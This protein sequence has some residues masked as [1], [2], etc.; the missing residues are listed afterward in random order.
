[1]AIQH[2]LSAKEQE[3]LHQFLIEL[4]G[5]RT[6]VLL[7]SRANEAWLARETFAENMYELAGLDP[8]ATSLLANLILARHK[9]S[10]YGKDP[11]LLKLLKLL[12][13]FP[14]ALEVILANLARQT[15]TEVLTALQSGDTTLQA[16]KGQ[17]R[18][19]NILRCVDYSYSNLAPDIQSLLLCL[20]PF[21]SVIFQPTL[22]WYITALKQQPALSSL[23]FER[24]Q[25]VIQGATD[26]GLLMEDTD[27][28][29]FLRLQPV[30][31][32]FLRTRLSPPEYEKMRN[33]I[34]KAFREL[35]DQLGP[36]MRSL[37]NSKDPQERQIGQ[38]LVRMEYENL[39]TAIRLALDAQVSILGPY[40]PLSEYVD[41]I[42]A[43]QQGLAFAQS[44]LQRFNA[45][46]NRSTYWSTGI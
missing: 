4:M 36:E 39:S 29:G 44:I 31:P 3:K 45:L 24:W 1:M 15:P 17:A 2:T 10:H 18:T 41:R 21:T 37:L 5:G 40:N 35:Y 11:D 28:P 9:V 33:A 14:L 34:E 20:A 46:P 27:V 19:E 13:G 12:D 7:G 16:G 6:L 26:W 43:P 23:P 22:D 38:L 32:Y 30:L 8:E 25:E 42:Q